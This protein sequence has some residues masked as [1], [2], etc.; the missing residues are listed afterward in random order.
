MALNLIGDPKVTDALRQWRGRTILP[1]HM[2]SA[3]LLTM[4]RGLRERSVFSARTTN[5]HYLQEI[6][7]VVDDISSGKI[8]M[9]TGRL[10]LM[11]KLKELGYDPTKGFPG[12]MAAVPP[13]EQDS[14]QDLGS[15][16]R[17]Q[18]VLE[19]NLRMGYNYGRMLA[20]NGEYER[21]A[22][23]AWELVRAYHRATPRGTPESHTDGWQRR[24]AAAGAAVDWKGAVKSPMVARK[25]SPLWQA[26]GDGDGD[27]SDALGNPYP[28]FAFG[29]GM[30]WRAVDRAECEALG[31][32]DE[33]LPEAASAASTAAS[34]ASPPV[35]PARQP[36]PPPAR[37][38]R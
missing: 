24:W 25:D 15:Y 11:H 14:L 22:Y 1:T 34:P 8:N 33:S 19:T 13:A 7:Q 37:R 16:R 4:A 6:A 28:P 29:S 36:A 5:A 21:R 38:R 35:R 30:G 9:A 23:P 12:D 18:L 2:G 17:L 3:D 31:L 20:G 26:L 27:Y 10:R 32:I